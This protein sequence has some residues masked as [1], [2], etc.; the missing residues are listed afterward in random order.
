MWHDRPPA[1]SVRHL[2]PDPKRQLRAL[3]VVGAYRD[4]AGQLSARIAQHLQT[5]AKADFAVWWNH[6]REIVGR[7][8]GAV[9]RAAD[10]AD[11]LVR[12][13]RHGRTGRQRPSRN[14]SFRWAG[15]ECTLAA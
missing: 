15:V 10:E 5:D 7:R 1:V 13:I 9:G 11:R 2:A 12:P 14:R 6:H 8:A 4:R 3:G